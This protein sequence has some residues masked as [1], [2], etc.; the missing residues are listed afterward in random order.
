MDWRFVHRARL[1]LVPQNGSFSWRTGNRRCRRC[2]HTIE[3]LAY[4]VN[5]CMQYTSLYMA[6]HNALVARLK[7]V[8]ERKFTVISENQVIGPQCL[9]LDLVLRRG[10]ATLIID[11]TVP[12]DNRLKA[13]RDSVDEKLSKYEELRKEIAADVSSEVSIDP[14]IVGSLGSWDPANDALAKQLTPSC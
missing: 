9:R 4:V 12:F 2:G 5:H 3:S 1:N 14:F 8:A 13:F 6:R 11:A 7:K 10:N